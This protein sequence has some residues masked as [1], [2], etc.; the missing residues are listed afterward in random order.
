MATMKNTGNSALKQQSNNNNDS[1]IF[2]HAS[3]T[4]VGGQNDSY[5]Q[6]EKSNSLENNDTAGDID[7]FEDHCKDKGIKLNLRKP[8]KFSNFSLQQ[9]QANKLAQITK[10]ATI[11]SNTSSKGFVAG[12]R[13]MQ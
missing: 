10:F 2:R 13:V 9:V 7:R 3:L 6:M 1:S 4:I 5:H 8:S 11:G 12:R